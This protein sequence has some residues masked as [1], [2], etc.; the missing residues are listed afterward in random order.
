M[1]TRWRH[2][3]EQMSAELLEVVTNLIA[4]AWNPNGS[5]NHLDATVAVLIDKFWAAHASPSPAGLSRGT[6][7]VS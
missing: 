2:E 6:S 1:D 5:D 7:R 3:F 4:V